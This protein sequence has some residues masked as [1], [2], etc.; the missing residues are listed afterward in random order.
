MPVRASA[1]QR[2]ELVRG[3]LEI[4]RQSLTVIWHGTT[5]EEESDGQPLAPEV[6]QAYS[7]A[8]FVG[9]LVIEEWIV[10]WYRQHPLPHPVLQGS[11]ARSRRCNLRNLVDPAFRV[12]HG[13][14]ERDLVAGSQVCQFFW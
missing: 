3:L 13:K 5:G 11:R 2:D 12:T 8:Q 4:F 1:W 6:A 14:P 7:L 10:G 9:E